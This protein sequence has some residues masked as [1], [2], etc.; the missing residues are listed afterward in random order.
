MYELNPHPL[1]L[2]LVQ[3]TER[4]IVRGV[5]SLKDG[6]RRLIEVCGFGKV[7]IFN[8]KKNLI[9]YRTSLRDCLKFLGFRVILTNTRWSALFFFF[10]SY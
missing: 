3:A 4:N 10:V 2:P 8:L 7:W 1:D 9:I 5:I 6:R